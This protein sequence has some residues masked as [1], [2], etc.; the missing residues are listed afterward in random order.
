[1]GTASRVLSSSAPRAPRTRARPSQSTLER[2]QPPLLRPRRRGAAST[3]RS[4]RSASVRRKIYE[5]DV[6]HVRGDDLSRRAKLRI[7]SLTAA[8][9][10]G[11]ANLD[12]DHPSRTRSKESRIR[13][14]ESEE[15]PERGR[16]P[17]AES[18]KHQVPVRNP[19]IRC[20]AAAAVVGGEKR[21]IR[22]SGVYQPTAVGLEVRS[23]TSGARGSSASRESEDVRNLIA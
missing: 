20:L 12:G 5:S 9:D 23:P 19:R 18:D 15:P 7:R 21:G 2:R 8:S 3:A 4:A 14:Q 22:E 1:M 11:S 17:A 13:R 6:R 10:G 16:S